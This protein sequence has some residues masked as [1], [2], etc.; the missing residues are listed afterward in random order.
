M[1]CLLTREGRARAAGAR[2]ADSGV[3]A[4]GDRP[5]A[6]AVLRCAGRV[7]G[8][9]TVPADARVLPFDPGDLRRGGHAAVS[10]GEEL[11]EL[12]GRHAWKAFG[13]DVFRGDVVELFA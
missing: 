5:G 7:V 2:G 11:D 4:I 3:V 8:A 13:D 9:P 12:G 6:R 10:G 1:R